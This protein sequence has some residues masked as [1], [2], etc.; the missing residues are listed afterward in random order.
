MTS[1]TKY[2]ISKALVWCGTISMSAGYY[3]ASDFR[4][5]AALVGAGIA[6]DIAAIKLTYDA[7]KSDWEEL[8]TRTY[9]NSSYDEKDIIDVEYVIVESA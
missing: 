3:L 6:A 4:V 2:K 5:K 1:N 9:D 7:V 8:E